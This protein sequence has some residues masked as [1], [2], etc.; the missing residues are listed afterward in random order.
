MPARRHSRL[1]ILLGAALVA[2][3]TCVNADQPI[4][5]AESRLFLSNHLDN[6]PDTAALQY[7]YTRAGSL[8]APSEDRVRVTISPAANGSGRQ[9]QVD[10]LTGA[11][12]FELPAIG[13]AHGNPV[14]LF[15]LERDVREMQRLTGG[16]ASYFRRRVRTALADA[17]EVRPVTLQFAGRSVAGEQIT[18]QPYRDDPL[19]ERFERLADKVYTFTLS[20]QIPGAVYR[21]QTL[22]S[23][24]GAGVDTPP[25]I[26]ETLTLVG[27][28]P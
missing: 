10:Y 5:V 28:E 6:L 22:V 24:P 27:A 19:R 26:A 14:I 3:G 13:A 9:V 4:S 20:D 8:E 17:A 2:C 7:A 1:P 16:Q 18:V 11:Q 12:H 15:F 21:V 23:A 25:L